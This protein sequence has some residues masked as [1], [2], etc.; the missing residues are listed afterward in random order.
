MSGVTIDIPPAASS[1]T[2][3]SLRYLELAEQL[4]AVR[5]RCRARV[6]WAVSAL[7][8]RHSLPPEHAELVAALAED[9]AERAAMPSW[10][11]R[12]RL[13]GWLLLHAVREAAGLL[14]LRRRCRAE[15]RRLSR[16][17]VDVVIKTW[18]FGPEAAA[19]EDDF[20]FGRLPQELRARGRR[21]LLLCGDTREAPDAAFARAALRRGD[22]APESALVPW[23][24]P[25]ATAVEQWSAAAE[26]ARLGRQSTTEPPLARVCAAACLSALRPITMRNFLHVYATRA[27]VRRWTPK[28]VVML[29]EGQPWEQP[30]WQGVK[31]ADP[32]CRI[33]GYQHTVVM[34][35]SLGLLAPQR[36]LGEIPAP[37]AVLC[38]GGVTRELLAPGQA[39]F[40][41]QLIMFGTHRR[42]AR[43]AHREPPHPQRRAILVLPEGIPREARLLFNAALRIARRL[44]EH[45]LIFRSHPVLPFEQVRPQLEGDPARLPNVELSPGGPLADDMDRASVVLYRGSSS[46]LYGIVRGLKPVYLHCPGVPDVD[47]LFAMSGWRETTAS[48]DDAV[49]RLEAYAASRADDAAAEWEPAAAYADAYTQAV[50]AAGI[51]ELCR[52]LEPRA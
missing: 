46:V 40:G 38:V 32:S 11:T 25:L 5:R 37:D 33:V 15:M 7:R 22:A 26:I 4:Y 12:L 6:L 16:E 45:R 36:I 23:W 43:E 21:C 20:Y 29:Y 42:T 28:A 2:D 27:A 30:A 18:W 31:A 35:H 51:D 48:P 44:P 1:Q 52:L 49:A 17:P 9:C 34:P 47:P 3:W 39:A 13:W 8:P 19:R 14:R 10:R 50:S 41:A 24:A